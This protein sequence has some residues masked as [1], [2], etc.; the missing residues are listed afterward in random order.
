LKDFEELFFNNKTLVLGRYY[1]HRMR[2]V[3][4]MDGTPLNISAEQFKCLPAFSV[5]IETIILYGVSS[6]A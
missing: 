2:M 1:V 4:V 6:P 3:T 5:R